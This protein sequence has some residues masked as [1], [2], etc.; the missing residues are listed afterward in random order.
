MGTTTYADMPLEYVT[1][2]LGVKVSLPKEI[3]TAILRSAGLNTIQDIIDN[4]N[5]F[6]SEVQIIIKRRLMYIKP[7]GM[8]Y[9]YAVNP[10]P[11]GQE[12]LQANDQ[13]NSWYVLLLEDPTYSDIR[14]KRLKDT[15]YAVAE[16]ERY[17]DLCHTNGQ[18]ALGFSLGEYIKGDEQFMVRSLHAANLF[19]DQVM[20]QAELHPKAAEKGENVFTRDLPS[21]IKIVGINYDRII[22]TALIDRANFVWGKDDTIGE[23]LKQRYKVKLSGS[24]KD[25]TIEK[26]ALYASLPEWEEQ[27][28]TGNYDIV[29]RRLKKP[30]N[31]DLKHR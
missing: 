24:H 3:N 27:A 30:L 12:Y 5:I 7:C 4:M 22:K 25:S 17:L 2:F 19:R 20:R 10:Y 13:L 6:S 8:A 26:L 29:L 21:R 15:N 1:E 23:K 11:Q 31:N 28:R 9:R 16:F 18:N 14:I